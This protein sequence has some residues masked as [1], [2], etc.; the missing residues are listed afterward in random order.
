MMRKAQTLWRFLTPR[1]KLSARPLKRLSLIVIMGVPDDVL[2]THCLIQKMMVAATQLAGMKM[3][4]KRPS[5]VWLML[6]VFDATAET[7]K[8]GRIKIIRGSSPKSDYQAIKKP[9]K[10]LTSRAF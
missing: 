9:A 7:S 2:K 10:S 1:R 5:R 3:C 4:A 6:S 8:R